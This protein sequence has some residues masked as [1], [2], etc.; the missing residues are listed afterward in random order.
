MGITITDSAKLLLVAHL[1][2]GQ[3]PLTRTAVGEA[4]WCVTIRSY[5]NHLASRERKDKWLMMLLLLLSLPPPHNHPVRILFPALSETW[6]LGDRVRARFLRASKSPN[7]HAVNKIRSL[8]RLCG[9][10]CS[11][12]LF[13][14]LYSLPRASRIVYSHQCFAGR[15]S[16]AE[17]SERYWTTQWHEH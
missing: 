4:L 17:K 7:A 9:R 10:S 15:I 11:D 14:N 1:S 2:H 12:I 8:R 16:S 13:I 3:D 5:V 6:P